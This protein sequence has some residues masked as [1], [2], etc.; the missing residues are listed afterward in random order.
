MIRETPVM[1][2]E[3]N[4]KFNL[5]S[6]LRADLV[7]FHRMS[8]GGDTSS[9]GGALLWLS[10]IS[11][12]FMP[13]LLCRLAHWFYLLRLSPLAKLASLVNFFL[14]GIEIA[15]RCPIGPGI[16]FP[17]T[18][19]TVIGALSIGDNVTIF[20]GTTLGAKE[21]D[22]SYSQDGRPIVGNNVTIGSGA[23]I[24]GGIFL[25]DGSRVGA[26]AVVLSDV[27]EG[28]LVV[29]VPAKAVDVDEVS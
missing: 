22:F 14:F 6:F 8:R 17:H 26:N 4:Q 1:T 25:G 10:I 23:K 21:I 11:P 9:S 27:P 12:R 5:R 28:V 20:Q 2:H 3:S 29:G 13:I 15:I 19:G 16:F 7:K 24:L 18:Q